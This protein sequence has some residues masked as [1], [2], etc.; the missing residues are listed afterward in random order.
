MRDG[1]CRVTSESAGAVAVVVLAAGASRR[2]GEAKQLVEVGGERLLERAVRVA[3]EAALGPV[4]VVLGAA[5]ERVAGECDL[6]RAWV[7]VNSGWE[8]GMASSVRAGVELVAGMPEIGGVVLMT[9][10]MPEVMAGH[11]R[12]LLG[13]SDLGGSDAAHDGATTATLRGGTVVGSGYGGRLG[14]PAY[15]PREEFR[16]LMALR[17]DAGA[18]ELLRG[19]RHV[20]L[21]GGEVDVDTVED[22]ARARGRLDGEGVT[23][24]EWVVRD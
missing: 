15:F 6:R 10:D 22:L 19:A 13:T 7:V 20:E 8:E 21:A 11:L 2:L 3:V 23:E 1:G 24:G 12:A 16:A 9:C 5:A 14:V 17:G 4:V 18:R